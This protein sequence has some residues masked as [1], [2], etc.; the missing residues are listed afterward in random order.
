[1][2]CSLEVSFDSEGLARKAAAVV[3]GEVDRRSGLSCKV[4]KSVLHV[5]ITA[6]RFA[7]LRARTV[8]CLRDLRVFLDAAAACGK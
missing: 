8:S 6:D 5:T 1:M 4:D 2:K 7:A 3:G